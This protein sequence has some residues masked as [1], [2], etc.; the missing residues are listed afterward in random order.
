MLK[1]LNTL[2]PETTIKMECENQANT[3]YP[4]LNFER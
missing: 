3:F 4:L 1:I 2:K